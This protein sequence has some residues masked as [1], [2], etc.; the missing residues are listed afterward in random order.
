M[1]N[2]IKKKVAKINKSINGTG[3]GPPLTSHLTDVEQRVV[4]IVGIQA[5][6]GL[7]NVEEVGFAQVTDFLVCFYKN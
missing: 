2:N 7:D 3:G 4:A 1:K 6:T 5:A